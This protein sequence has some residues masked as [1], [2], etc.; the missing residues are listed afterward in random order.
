MFAVRYAAL[1]ALAVWFGVTVVLAMLGGSGLGESGRN[2][3]LLSGLC[4]VA[5]LICLFVMKFVG[6]PPRAFPMRATLV[7]LM[8]LVG[9]ASR[10]APALLLANLLLGLILLHWYV[11][12]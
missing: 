9:A 2:L 12:E 10:F 6:P 8:L 7:G 5:I 4:G 3:H 1:V 11:R